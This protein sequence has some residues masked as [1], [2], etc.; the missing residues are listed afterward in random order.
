MK[1]PCG[2]LIKRVERYERELENGEYEIVDR[3][4]AVADLDKPGVTF[5]AAKG[6]KPGLGNRILAGKT[7]N[8]GRLRKRCLKAK[9]RVNPAPPSITS[10]SSRLSLMSVL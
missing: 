1:V 3:M 4:E 10:W 2:T 6:G 5:L 9:P 7:T 8:F